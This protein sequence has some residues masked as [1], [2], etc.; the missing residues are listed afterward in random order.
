MRR[1][2][3][4]LAEIALGCLIV[5]QMFCQWRRIAIQTGS[6]AV[7]FSATDLILIRGMPSTSYITTYRQAVADN[8]YFHWFQAWH[9]GAIAAVVVRLDHRNSRLRGCHLGSKATKDAGRL[10]D[11]NKGECYGSGLKVDL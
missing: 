5:L 10:P 9:F 1:A 4:I 3:R 2:T 8:P 11:G 7:Q 6:C